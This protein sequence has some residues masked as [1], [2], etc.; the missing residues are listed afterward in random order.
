MR[1]FAKTVYGLCVTA[2]VVLAILASPSNATVMIDCELRPHS[3]AGQM[4]S[5]D[6]T[7]D[8][9]ADMALSGAHICGNCKAHACVLATDFG[10]FNT[11]PEGVVLSD[12]YRMADG[13]IIL[14][15]GPEGL[16]RPPRS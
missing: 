9:D 2:F 7:T 15:Q 1:T 3:G 12:G 6:V 11:V 16:L 4:P 14:I 5:V 13:G 8:D 10:D